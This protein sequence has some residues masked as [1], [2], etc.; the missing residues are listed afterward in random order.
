[1]KTMKV[2]IYLKETSQR[3]TFETATNTYTK[4]P[5]FCVYLKDEN[6]VYKYPLDNIFNVRETYDG[7]RT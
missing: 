2:D 7:T 4:G 1:M 5:F 3:I 6:V